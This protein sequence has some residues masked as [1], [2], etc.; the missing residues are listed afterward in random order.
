M[1][2]R[3]NRNISASHGIIGGFKVTFYPSGEEV[4]VV[5]MTLNSRVKPAN[6][7]FEPGRDANRI[8]VTITGYASKPMNAYSNIQVFGCQKDTGGAQTDISLPRSVGI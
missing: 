3:Q 8:R 4:P 6:F 7:A 5:G 1:Y 2:L